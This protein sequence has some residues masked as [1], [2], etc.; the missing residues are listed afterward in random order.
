MAWLFVPGLTAWSKDCIWPSEMP[1]GLSLAWN[2]KQVQSQSW[3]RVSRTAVFRR[4]LFGTTC[5]HSLLESG[6]AEF[7]SSLA[8]YPAS[9]TAS[10]E[11]GSEP[12]T[13][14]TSGPIQ[15]VLSGMSSPNGSSWKTCLTCSPTSFIAGCPSYRK[16]ATALR[17]RSSRLRTSARPTGGNASS[18]WPTP[19]AEEQDGTRDHS[20][21]KNGR[22]LG[23][24]A[25]AMW[26]TPNVPE[27][28]RTS[29][30]SNYREDGSKRQADLG[31]VASLWQT[32]ATDS[33]RSRGGER[34]DEAGLDQQARMW[35]TPNS[36]MIEPKPLGTKLTN[37]SPTDPQ[38]GLADQ[39]ASFLPHPSTPTDGEPSSNAGPNSR[40]R[41]NP[42]FV[43]WLMNFPIGWTSLAPLGSGSRAT[44][45]SPSRLAWHGRYSA[46]DTVK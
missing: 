13:N 17:R 11:S 18:S 41:L 14:A 27:G 45:S 26:P 46:G 37:R 3:L 5:E 25:A 21:P 4:F 7:I 44:A 40:R 32:P 23:Q 35:R 19:R 42:L 10:P 29:N 24:F 8:A 12:Q 9:P 33:F 43:E 30:V 34:V 39:A 1:T 6:V 28:G 20:N 15:P 36:S 38:V 31:A 22:M 2:T 16:W